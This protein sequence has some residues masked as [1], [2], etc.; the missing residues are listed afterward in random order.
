MATSTARLQAEI[1]AKDEASKVFKSVSDRASELVKG[2]GKFQE[3]A[4]EFGRDMMVIGGAGALALKSFVDSANEAERVQTQ[5]NAVL[6]STGGI[7]GVTADQAL[8]LSTELQKVTTV[9]DEAILSGENM[10]LTFTN[11]SKDVFPRVTETMLDMAVAMNNGL[12][13]S[14]EQL[15]SQAI[16]LGKALNNPTEGLTALT[17]VGVAFTEQ[18]KQQIEHLQKSGDLMGAQKIILAEL[19]KEFGGS[20]QA[21]A[22]TFSGQMENLKNRMGDLGE[23]LGKALVPVLKE[24][25]NKIGELITWFEKLSPSEKEFIAQTLAIGTALALVLGSVALFMANFNPLV[26]GVAAGFVLLTLRLKESGVSWEEFA[27]RIK[28]TWAELEAY[29]LSKLKKLIDLEAAIPII[30]ERF[31]QYQENYAKAIQKANDTIVESDIE[32]V[33]VRAQKLEEQK[34]NLEDSLSAQ[35]DIVEKATG[36]QKTIA[37][38]QYEEMKRDAVKKFSDLKLGTTAEVEAMRKAQAEQLKK[39]AQSFYDFINSVSKSFQSFA[40]SSMPWGKALIDNIT[41][42]MVAAFPAMAKAI[43]YAQNAMRTVM[44][45][46]K[47]A[48]NISP[49]VPAI[50]KMVVP[51]FSASGGGGASDSAAKKIDEIKKKFE[52]A[53]QSYQDLNIKA[54]ESLEELKQKHIDKLGEIAQKIEDTKQKIR[55]LNDNYKINVQGVDTSVGEKVVE[56]QQLVEDL[57]KQ[58]LD[59]TSSGADTSGLQE[60]L[61]KEQAALQAF[62]AT[63]KGYED[64]IVEAQRRANET[65][66]ERFI[67]DA[68]KRKDVLTKEHD[69]KLAALEAEKASLQDQA[70]KEMVIFQQKLSQY[71]QLQVGFMAMETTFNEGLSNM[72]KQAQDKVTVINQQLAVMKS[73]MD[74]IA[75]LSGAKPLTSSSV[76]ASTPKFATGGVVTRPTIAMIGEG[77]MNEAVVPLPNGRS[78]PVQMQGQSGKPVVVNINI[79]G[80]H[81][82]SSDRD[83]ESFIQKIEN[84]LAR[85]IQLQ[86]LGSLA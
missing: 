23:E 68:T 19:A 73:A 12:T 69:D 25:A 70:D 81:Y 63:A 49:S 16:Q 24:F 54:G 11:I 20:A 82:I 13:P 26:A 39:I 5:L 35:K 29:V 61:Q 17:R 80:D 10:L 65:G 50:P 33:K 58:I 75:A 27:V 57:K 52:E 84:R 18:Q 51:S 36:D 47:N 30:G 9:G 37:S 40:S 66:F 45:F 85:A 67:E 79:T 83:E 53:K 6:K 28:K 22:K 86:Q 62:M 71:T 74:Q 1:T 34:R 42:G 41:K 59:A 31:V 76:P 43:N 21:A 55:D 56:Q 7:A 4:G 60:K 3:I 8:K 64:E 48:S 15:S 77:N 78:I 2:F 38:K 44:G 14:A 72:A 32:I 46:L